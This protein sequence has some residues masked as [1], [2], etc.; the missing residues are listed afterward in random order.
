MDAEDEDYEDYFIYK[1]VVNRYQLDGKMLHYYAF[2]MLPS[3]KDFTSDLLFLF[4]LFTVRFT[5]G[6]P[7]SLLCSSTIPLT[8]LELRWSLTDTQQDLDRCVYVWSESIPLSTYDTI[9]Y[10]GGRASRQNKILEM[11]PLL[12]ITF[13]PWSE[14]VKN[15]ILKF[16]DIV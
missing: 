3:S 15:K 1:S 13:D 9:R 12:F 14:Y 4:Y 2:K 16:S 11:H 8:L 6:A 5:I 7:L 10:K